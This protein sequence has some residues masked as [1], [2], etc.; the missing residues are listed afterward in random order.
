[1]KV[2]GMTVKFKSKYKE[3][4][5][6]NYM[7]PEQNLNGTNDGHDDALDANACD[8][9]AQCGD[10]P[11]EQALMQLFVSTSTVALQRHH[12]K[13]IKLFL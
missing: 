5:A 13:L 1:M 7:S 11:V 6:A 4:G 2:R 9:D 10:S 3:N 8:K 12:Y